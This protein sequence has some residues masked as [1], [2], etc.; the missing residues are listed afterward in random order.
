MNPTKKQ[1]N[2][3]NNFDKTEFEQFFNEMCKQSD[4][5]DENTKKKHQEQ[6]NEMRKTFLHIKTFL[7]NKQEE[8]NNTNSKKNIENIAQTKP[9]TSN[10]CLNTQDK[11]IQTTTYN[12]NINDPKYNHKQNNETTLTQ[13][14]QQQQQQEQK[15]EEQKQQR[16]E[17]N[18]NVS[19]NQQKQQQNKHYPNIP[20]IQ[21][22]QQHPPS[23]ISSDTFFIT[24]E[25]ILQNFKK[26][27][28]INDTQNPNYTHI[29]LFRHP[30]AFTLREYQYAKRNQ[31]ICKYG[32]PPSPNYNIV[33]IN[34]E[35]MFRCPLVSCEHKPLN[36][37]YIKQS[38][39]NH[40]RCYHQENTNYIFYYKQDLTWITL[41]YPP[42][43]MRL[44]HNNQPDNIQKGQKFYRNSY[45]PNDYYKGKG[46]SP[47]L[48]NNFY[49]ANKS[50]GKQHF[51]T[52]SNNSYYQNKHK[53]KKTCTTSSNNFN[54]PND[55]YKGK[56]PQTTLPHI[57]ADTD[58]CEHLG[59]EIKK[60]ANCPT[61]ETSTE[62]KNF[63]Q[64]ASLETKNFNETNS[65]IEEEENESN[66]KHSENNDE[67]KL[68]PNNENN[69]LSASTIPNSLPQQITA[70][71]S[72]SQTT[73]S[74]QNKQ[75][76]PP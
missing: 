65:Q 48:P 23:I 6:K 72:P 53:G 22:Q 1:D 5:S 64:S 63:P 41:Y 47:T 32:H 45:N 3:N 76:I 55:Y 69:E 8:E 62:Y 60:F 75:I 30:T 33:D 28:Y 24:K 21:H 68:I 2:S 10:T 17:Q 56:G 73:L 4:T 31:R 74:P 16:K 18:N 46:P 20:T 54:N 61:P 37:L 34:K 43:P 67:I 44:N 71:E 70:E 39:L 13:Q 7:N 51:E 11:H 59:Q 14:Q 58:N 57:V 26:Y 25:E 66:C 52:S 49:Y 40:C 42:L 50:K 29:Y 9:N 27:G 38:L 36:N 35:T 12:D 19:L 15:E